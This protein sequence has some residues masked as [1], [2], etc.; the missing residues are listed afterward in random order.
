MKIAVMG[1]GGVGGYFGGLLARAGMDVTFIV[2][3]PHLAAVKKDGLRVVSDLSGEFTVKGRATDDTASVGSVDLV[4]YTVKMYHNSQAIP[5]VRPMLGSETVVLTLQNG[6]ENGEHLAAGLGAQHV[7]VGTAVVLAGIER[8]GLVLQRGQVGNIVFGDP[9]GGISDRGRTLLEVFR[10][11]SWNV[12]LSPNAMQALW[13]KF[14][15]LT[16]SATVN[17]VTQIT[18]GEMRAIP[19][20]RE[21]IKSAWR[22]IAAVGRACGVDP[23]DDVLDWC[24]SS[25]DAFPAQGRTSLANDFQA[26]RPVE[27]EGLTGTVVRL[28]REYGVPTPVHSTMYALLKPAALRNAVESAGQ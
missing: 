7:M 23:G 8:P 2:R 16:G 5:A 25:L 4:L 17:A 20:T 6:V 18:Y 3:G 28:G 11:G 22:E 24:E 19:E 10:S 26:G 14:V 13:R 9:G 27:L 15:Y 12:E 21:L 1:A